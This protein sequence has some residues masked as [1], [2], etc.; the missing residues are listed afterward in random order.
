MLISRL[1]NRAFS[2][3]SISTFCALYNPFHLCHKPTN[4][5]NN[6]PVSGGVTNHRATNGIQLGGSVFFNIPEHGRLRAV[7]ELLIQAHGIA[8]GVGATTGNAHGGALPHYLF[9][10]LAAGF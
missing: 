8:G 3:L 4:R 6:N 1:H 7:F 2:S 5:R 10:F 9:Q